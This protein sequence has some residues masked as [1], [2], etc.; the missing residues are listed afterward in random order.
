MTGTRD[1][2]IKGVI[3]SR[4]KRKDELVCGHTQSVTSQESFVT[5]MKSALVKTKKDDQLVT[6]KL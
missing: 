3:A 4:K 6:G 1:G 5:G 2:F